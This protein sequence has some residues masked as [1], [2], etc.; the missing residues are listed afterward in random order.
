M[1]AYSFCLWVS[2]SGTNYYL[3]FFD[4]AYFPNSLSQR[5][6]WLIAT[7][8]KVSWMKKHLVPSSLLNFSKSRVTRTKLVTDMAFY[9]NFFPI[10]SGDQNSEVSLCCEKCYPQPRLIVFPAHSSHTAT[11]MSHWY[12]VWHR[13]SKAGDRNWWVVGK[14]P[15]EFWSLRIELTN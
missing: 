6:P 15:T 4:L 9:F 11:I 8:L 10:L 5:W 1:A 14:V 7:T 3:M 13:V 12:R 2:M